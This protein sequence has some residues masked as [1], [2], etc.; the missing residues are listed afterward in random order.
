MVKF[1]KR[2]FVK[3]LTWEGSGAIILFALYVCTGRGFGEGAIFALGYTAIRVAMFYLH[4]R[5]WKRF[6]WG[7]PTLPEEE[8]EL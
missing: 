2:T 5:I 3:A 8:N 7:K 6:D 1:H 4:A